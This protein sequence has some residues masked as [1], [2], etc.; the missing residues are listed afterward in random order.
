MLELLDY[1]HR[2][3]KILEVTFFVFLNYHRAYKE[4]VDE[5]KKKLVEV[6]TERLAKAKQ[7]PAFMGK[8]SSDESSSDEGD[9]DEDD[10]FAVNWRAQHL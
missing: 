9:D 4:R 5:I 6:R 2:T 3:V 8:Q 1:I 7:R 10:N